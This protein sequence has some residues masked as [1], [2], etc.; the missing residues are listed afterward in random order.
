MILLPTGSPVRGLPR[1]LY[2]PQDDLLKV[3]FYPRGRGLDP[4]QGVSQ[5]NQSYLRR[6]LRVGGEERGET[7]RCTFV[8]RRPFPI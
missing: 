6:T 3:Y 2:R 5:M 7:E 8:H 1:R 4:F